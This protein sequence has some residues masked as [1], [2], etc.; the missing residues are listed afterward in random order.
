M[1]QKNPTINKSIFAFVKSFVCE[2][3]KADATQEGS[4]T[5]EATVSEHETVVE[6]IAAQEAMVK[7][8][9]DTQ[10]TASNQASYLS[11][12]SSSDEKELNANTN[13][14]KLDNQIELDVTET[15]RYQ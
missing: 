4:S 1:N 14:I 3:N 8:S 10:S 2:K 11:Q 6:V 13:E 5:N 15:F 9:D 7:V 12:I